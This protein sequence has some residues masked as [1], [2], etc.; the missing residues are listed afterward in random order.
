MRALGT[1]QTRRRDRS[2]NAAHNGPGERRL[3]R[4]RVAN[5]FTTLNLDATP[6]AVTDPRS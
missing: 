6:V 5:H 1:A 2:R 3:A 4:L